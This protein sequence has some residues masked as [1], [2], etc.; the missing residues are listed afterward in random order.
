MSSKD[1]FCCCGGSRSSDQ[2]ADPHVELSHSLPV[3]KVNFAELEAGRRL[4]VATYSGQTLH[5]S[6]LAAEAAH[7]QEVDAVYCSSSSACQAVVDTAHQL[8]PR[9]DQTLPL[10][11]SERGKIFTVHK[12]QEFFLLSSIHDCLDDHF[13]AVAPD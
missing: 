11:T 5:D 6:T 9:D 1:I 10:H 2:T 3:D 13:I 7:D 12:R 4:C 8:L